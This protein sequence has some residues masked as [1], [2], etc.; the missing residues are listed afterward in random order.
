MTMP[1]SSAQPAE[2]RLSHA[3]DYVSGPIGHSIAIQWHCGG[4]A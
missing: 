3:P 4:K 1:D 2:S